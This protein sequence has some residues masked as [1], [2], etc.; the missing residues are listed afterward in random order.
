MKNGNI[1]L[2]KIK[3]YLFYNKQ[4]LYLFLSILINISH[5]NGKLVNLKKHF[6]EIHLILKGSGNRSILNKG[7][8][9]E[10]SFVEVNGKSKNCKKSCNFQDELNNVTLYFNYSISKCEKMFCGLK[11]IIEIDMTK[12]DFSNVIITKSM[13]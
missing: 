5:S 11:N 6:S 4:I 13:F 9:F 7:Y 12:F 3:L 10:P 2:N 8:I 1:L